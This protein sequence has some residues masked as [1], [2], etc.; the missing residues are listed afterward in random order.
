MHSAKEHTHDIR[1]FQ[2]IEADC[3]NSDSNSTLL[4]FP[5]PQ[6][7]VDSGNSQLVNKLAISMRQIA[8]LGARQDL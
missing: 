7:R 6:S 2:T 8:D 3:L 5:R 4:D 1:Q